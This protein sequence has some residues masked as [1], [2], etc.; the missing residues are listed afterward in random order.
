MEFIMPNS[1]IEIR[2]R[3]FENCKGLKKIIFSQNLEYIGESAFAD[4]D[5]LKDNPMDT[6]GIFFYAKDRLIF[7][8]CM[9]KDAEEY[10]DFLIYPY[11]HDEIWEKHYKKIYNVDFDYYPRGRIVYN[12]AEKSFWIYKDKC[13]ASLILLSTIINNLGGINKGELKTDEH[14]VCHKCNE[15]YCE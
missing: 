2:E 1:V 10:G 8:K 6:V 3:A 4:C 13:I 12:T 5:L 9:L 7:H 14:Y 15:E 11:S